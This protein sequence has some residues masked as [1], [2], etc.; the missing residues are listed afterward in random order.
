M[1]EEVVEERDEHFNSIHPVIPM[2][3]EQ[4]VKENVNTPAPTVSDDDMDLLDDDEVPL[5]KDRS[6]PRIGM[7]ISMVFTLPIECRGVE[8]E[9][10]QMCFSPKEAVFEKPEESSKHL[11]LL[12]I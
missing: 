2:K 7:D 12:Y 1:R 5:I 3:Q 4:R 8:E 10:A 11:K 6:P 9:A